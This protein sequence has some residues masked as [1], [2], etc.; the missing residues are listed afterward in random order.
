MPCASW[1]ATAADRYSGPWDR[2]TANPVLVLNTTHDPS[3]P[4]EGA[5]AMSQQLARAR[6]LTV[7]GYGHIAQSTDSACVTH[8]ITRYLIRTKLPPEGTRCGQDQQPFDAG[9]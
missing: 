9:P 3:T 6:L 8:H 7:D 5:V 1:R 4:Y 2:R